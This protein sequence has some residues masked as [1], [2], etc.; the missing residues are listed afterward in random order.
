MKSLGRC[1]D[2]V[3][4][5]W[6]TTTAMCEKARTALGLSDP[7]VGSIYH[8]DYPRGCSSKSDGSAVFFNNN[9]NSI[10]NCESTLLCLCA[11]TARACDHPDGSTPHTSSATCVCGAVARMCTSGTGMYCNAASSL[12]GAQK[13]HLGRLEGRAHCLLR[14][15]RA[16]ASRT[17]RTGLWRVQSSPLQESEI[18]WASAPRQHQKRACATI[19]P[20]PGREAYIP[21]ARSPR[22]TPSRTQTTPTSERRELWED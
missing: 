13:D 19:A 4:W 1:D 9:V 12:C 20:Y 10:K 6:I 3:G 7:G 11:V 15:L 5:G 2:D 18:A 22:S 21:A 8:D 17:G 16:A 14:T